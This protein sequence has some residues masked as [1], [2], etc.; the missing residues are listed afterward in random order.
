MKLLLQKQQLQELQSTIVV[1]EPL[2]APSETSGICLLAK[3][4]RSPRAISPVDWWYRPACKSRR[5]PAVYQTSSICLLLRVGK[6]LW[7]TGLDMLY[8]L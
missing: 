1:V 2:Q 3:V 6:D 5:I 8:Q 4:D 7:S